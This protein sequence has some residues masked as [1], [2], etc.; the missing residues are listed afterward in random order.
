MVCERMSLISPTKGSSGTPLRAT[1]LRLSHLTWSGTTVTFKT[2]HP[3]T[4]F[5]VLSA[6]YKKVGSASTART[7]CASGSNSCQLSVLSA[8]PPDTSLRNRPFP[9]L[10]APLQSR[11]GFPQ[12]VDLSHRSTCRDGA[13]RVSTGNIFRWLALPAVG[14]RLG[15]S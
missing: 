4:S 13:C 3:T 8:C 10:K 2:Y 6:D 7:R 14:V 12:V 9:R 1:A 5:P 15:Q 11:K